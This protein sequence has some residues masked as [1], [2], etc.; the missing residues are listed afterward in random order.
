MKLVLGNLVS[1][2]IREEDFTEAT[3]GQEEV[4]LDKMNRGQMKKEDWT[5]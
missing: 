1:F 2:L 4:V 5:T 3:I